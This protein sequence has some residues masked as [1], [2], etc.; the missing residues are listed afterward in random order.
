MILFCRD[1]FT[2]IRKMGGQKLLRNFWN[3][4]GL[5]L[6]FIRKESF[7]WVSPYQ[8]TCRISGPISSNFVIGQLS[9]LTP[10]PS[11]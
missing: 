6:N 3:R 11:P 9:T 8:E 10:G 2:V 1:N 4:L 5:T 7:S